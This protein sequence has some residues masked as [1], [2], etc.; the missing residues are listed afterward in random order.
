MSLD[1]SDSVSSDELLGRYLPEKTYFSSTGNSVKPKAFMPPPDLRLSVFR[2][3]GLNLEEIW[4]LGQV[5]V[6]NIMTVSKVLYGVANIRALKIK[7]NR[8]EIDPDNIPLRHVNIIGWPKEK[9][10]QMQIAQELAAEADL[11]LKQ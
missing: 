6:I 7:K 5:K 2:I 3:D 11:V 4:K 1:L 10:R 9:E 8:L